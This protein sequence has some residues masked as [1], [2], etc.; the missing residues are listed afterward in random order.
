MKKEVLV[1]GFFFLGLILLGLLTFRVD[2]E[3]RFFGRG[4]EKHYKVQFETAKHLRAGDP[5]FV[6]ERRAGHITG[7][8]V[9]KV[10]D[11]RDG[12]EAKRYVVEFDFAVRAPAR[13][14][15]DSEATIRT[16]PLL[17]FRQLEITLGTPQA[18]E[19]EEGELVRSIEPGA[20]LG[21]LIARLDKTVSE[22]QPALREIVENVRQ[23]RGVVGR[24]IMD[25]QMGENLAA[26]VRNV[27]TASESLNSQ[28]GTLGLLLNDPAVY[29]ELRNLL[30]QAGSAV[31]DA[32]EQAPI[33]VFT[34][35]IFGALQ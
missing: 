5:V 25:E 27:R 4:Q 22:I 23:G 14:R 6:G 8:S 19:L 28:E 30:D 17:G 15:E 26:I 33:A 29:N 10:S 34:S 9:K 13:L 18:G 12:Q 31:E 7:V 35:M 16:N 1:G 2:T 3:N 24:L 21:R 11:V 20:D 32:R